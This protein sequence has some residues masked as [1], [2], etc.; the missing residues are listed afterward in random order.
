MKG[1]YVLFIKVKKDKRIKIGTLGEIYFLK[2][3]YAYIGSAQNN[4]EKRLKRHILKR[5]KEFWHIDYLLRNK[6]VEIIEIFYEEGSKEKEC[7]TAEYFEKKYI[8]IV[9]FGSSD[10]KCKAHLFRIDY[11][12]DRFFKSL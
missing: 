3:I 10:C 7:K 8:P 2:G 9:G 4:L 6:D 12:R 5:K 1:I 11:V